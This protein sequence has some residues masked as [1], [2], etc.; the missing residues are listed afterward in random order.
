MSLAEDLDELVGT[1]RPRP[2]VNDRLAAAVQQR[3]MAGDKGEFIHSEFAVKGVTIQWLSD[4]F[5]MDPKVVKQKLLACPTLYEK[6]T[7]AVYSLPV[8]AAYLIKPALTPQDFIKAMKGGELPPALQAQFW[9]AALKRQ[10]FE[11]NAGQ[12]WRT[13]RVMAVFVAT[14]QTIK[15]SMQLFPD[16]IERTHGLT[17]EQRALLVELCDGL[18]QEIY[19]ALLLQKERDATGSALAEVPA[20][21]GE[22][23]VEDDDAL[24]LV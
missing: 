11:E 21:T 5:G 8:A 22:A 16:T 9:D 2:N 15:F 14:F 13:E 6:K 20:M 7:G 10:K 1:P 23:V 17:E 18:Q 4:V 12:L 19:E 24:E 3:R